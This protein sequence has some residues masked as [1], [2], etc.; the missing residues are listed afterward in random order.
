MVKY[1]VNEQQIDPLCEDENGN[2]AL[3]IACAGGH[4]AVVE[5]L[6]SELKYVPITELMNKLQN[7][8]SDTP[9]HSCD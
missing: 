8:W 3:H 1:L 4:Q 5:F 9:L 7:K 6:T 2:T